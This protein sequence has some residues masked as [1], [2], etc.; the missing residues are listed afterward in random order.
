M[1][2]VFKAGCADQKWI[3]CGREGGRRVREIG[4]SLCSAVASLPFP[5]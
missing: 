1:R 5:L 3:G 4:E 2:G